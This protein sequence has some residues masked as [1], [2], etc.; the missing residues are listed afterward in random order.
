MTNRKFDV[1]KVKDTPAMIA[2]MNRV[3]SIAAGQQAWQIKQEAAQRKAVMAGFEAWLAKAPLAERRAFLEML[4]GRATGTAADRI[5]DYAAAM[6]ESDPGLV[7]P[8][9]TVV[10]GPKSASFETP[11]KADKS[12]N[13]LK[14]DD[15]EKPSAD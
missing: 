6:T 2:A 11:A 13:L 3:M 4:A 7:R 14:G 12:L 10:E 15:L 5:S 8:S 1:K 9:V